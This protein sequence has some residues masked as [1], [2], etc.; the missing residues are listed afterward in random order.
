[1]YCKECG[2]EIND[3]AVVCIHCGCAVGDSNNNSQN[4]QGYITI[5]N[6]NTIGGSNV[7]NRSWFVSLIL[8]ILGGWLG[9]HRFYT[10]YTGIGILQLISCGGFVI[11]WVIDIIAIFLHC[12][13]CADGGK[14]V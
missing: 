6:T 14:L 5:V 9:L 8:C 11:W 4:N 12:Y 1:M 3:K 2:K 7:R 10:G 13:E